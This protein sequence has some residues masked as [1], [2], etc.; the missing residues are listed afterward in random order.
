VLVTFTAG[1]A[2]TGAQ[3][4]AFNII[5][6]LRMWINPQA[7]AG[8]VALDAH[9]PVWMTG[10]AGHQILTCFACMPPCPFVGRQNGINMTDLTLVFVKAVMCRTRG[11]HGHAAEAALM[12]YPG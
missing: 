1:S 11:S 8:T 9:I 5:P 7:T 4:S 10:L 6:I 3:H 2:V 12:R